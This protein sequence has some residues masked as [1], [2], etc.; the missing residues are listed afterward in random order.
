MLSILYLI[1]LYLLPL[2]LIGMLFSSGL[3]QYWFS[4]VVMT[5][6]AIIIFVKI[7]FAISYLDAKKHG[8]HLPNS[9]ILGIGLISRCYGIIALLA[10]AFTIIYGFATSSASFNIITNISNIIVFISVIFVYY[11]KI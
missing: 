3:Y 10:Y 6:S 1:S 5:T 11:R 8:V 7:G 4:L 9:S 2:S